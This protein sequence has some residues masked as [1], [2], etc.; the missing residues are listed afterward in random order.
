MII[1]V[2]K[3]GKVKHVYCSLPFRYN[4]AIFFTYLYKLVK[5]FW[6]L[7]VGFSIKIEF[8]QDVI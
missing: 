3:E 6:L 5:V 1:W 7:T 4:V 2:I 8:K